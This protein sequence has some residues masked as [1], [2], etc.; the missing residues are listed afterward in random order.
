[1]FFLP[2][3]YLSTISGLCLTLQWCAESREAEITAVLPGYQRDTSF[4][5]SSPTVSR[6]HSWLATLGVP[7]PCLL[8]ASE[9]LIISLHPLNHFS[10]KHCPAWLLKQSKMHANTNAHAQTCTAPHTRKEVDT[11]A[12]KS[13]ILWLLELLQ[14]KV[15]KPPSQIFIFLYHCITRILLY[16]SSAQLPTKAPWSSDT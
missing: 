1:M 11:D 14:C 12:T 3:R 5:N 2:L 7:V 10:L 16:L 6:L 9:A 13:L 8:S 15:Y 4:V